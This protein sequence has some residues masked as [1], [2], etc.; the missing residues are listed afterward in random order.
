M[1]D[2][3]EMPWEDVEFMEPESDED[4]VTDDSS[5]E[6]EVEEVKKQGNL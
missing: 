4:Q 6:E 5:A 1:V 2:G 3:K